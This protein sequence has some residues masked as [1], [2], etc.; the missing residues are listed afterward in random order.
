MFCHRRKFAT[1]LK[2]AS[3]AGP[4]RARGWKDH[5]TILECYQQPDPDTMRVALENRGTLRSIRGN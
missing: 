5:N 3:L 4:L 2:G 1:E